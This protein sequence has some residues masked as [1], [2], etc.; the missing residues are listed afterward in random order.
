MVLRRLLRSNLGISSMYGAKRE[1]NKRG[2]PN[3]WA[4]ESELV[5][6]GSRERS[7][8]IIA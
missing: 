3:G 1:H 4:L 5:L 2:K 7:K 8:G 6:K